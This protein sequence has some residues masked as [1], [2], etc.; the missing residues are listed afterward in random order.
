MFTSPDG[1]II[2]YYIIS[3]LTHLIF[4]FVFI[5][6]VTISN[7]QKPRTLSQNKYKGETNRYRII[8]IDPLA[9]LR[10]DLIQPACYTCLP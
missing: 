9:A 5:G 10:H 2:L 6:H 1:I 7:F 8:L 4:F 3:P